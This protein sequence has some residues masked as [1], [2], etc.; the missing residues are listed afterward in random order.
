MLNAAQ[1]VFD[2]VSSPGKPLPTP[3]DHTSYLGEEAESMRWFLLPSEAQQALLGQ[4]MPLVTPPFQPRRYSE[5]CPPR[6]IKPEPLNKIV[7]TKKNQLGGNKP[8][9]ETVEEKEVNKEQLLEEEARG[10]EKVVK[11]HSPPKTIYKPTTEV[12]AYIIALKGIING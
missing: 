9:E 10:T 4:A 1:K 6:T 3:S 7:S 2:E 5:S 8:S 12:C 11:F